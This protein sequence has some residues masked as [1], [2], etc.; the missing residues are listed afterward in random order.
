MEKNEHFH[1]WM[2][3]S[4]DENEITKWRC[5]W[6]WAW[7]YWWWLSDEMTWKRQKEIIIVVLTIL[8]PIEEDDNFVWLAVNF[9]CALFW[10]FSGNDYHFFENS[11]QKCSWWNIQCRNSDLQ[12]NWQRR[13]WILNE[14]ISTIFNPLFLATEWGPY[15]P[16]TKCDG[17]SSNTW[18]WSK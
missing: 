1:E 10:F 18:G 5:S 4:R 13:W 15:R 16:L 8:I 11:M 2:T 12:I 6:K 3:I 9:E 7:R 17:K 14:K